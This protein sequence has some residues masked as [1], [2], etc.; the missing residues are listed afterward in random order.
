MKKFEAD[1]AKTVEILTA[2]L[3]KTKAAK[4]KTDLSFLAQDIVFEKHLRSRRA[5]CLGITV[6]AAIADYLRLRV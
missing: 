3:E 6:S 2:V 1:R 4:D 5:A